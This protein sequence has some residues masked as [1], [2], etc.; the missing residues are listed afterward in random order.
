MNLVIALLKPATLVV[1][2]GLVSTLQADT[3]VIPVP[4]LVIEP[5]L[6]LT[7]VTAINVTDLEI[8]LVTTIIS[9]LVIALPRLQEI[10]R[11]MSLLPLTVLAPLVLPPV[12]LD[13]QRVT[14][15]PTDSFH[16]QS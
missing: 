9:I 13:L 5:V 2:A 11:L 3:P 15:T 7:L 8:V 6:N 16:H 14:L 10:S 12:L 1:K 4:I